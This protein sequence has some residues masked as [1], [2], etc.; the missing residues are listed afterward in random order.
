MFIIIVTV[1]T[2]K[3][4]SAESQKFLEIL[5]RSGLSNKD[6]A[7]KLGITPGQI[8]NITKGRRLPSRAIL[9]KLKDIYDVDLDWYLSDESAPPDAEQDEPAEYIVF[10]DQ[11]AAAGR[12]FEIEEHAERK[13]LPVPK[14]LL[15]RHNPKNV[16]AVAIGGDSMK[17]EKINEG[18]IVLFSK[19]V[20]SG[21]GIY[22]VS[23]GSEL[24]CKRVD[25]SALPDSLT[26]ISANPAYARREISNADLDT[27]KIEGRVIAVLHRE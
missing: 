17:D 4:E 7:R 10:Y 11:K 8:T 5:R 1:N 12:G 24:V 13:R 27:V 20:T 23:L 16:Y 6:F 21:N 14:S 19:D 22:I 9:A 15:G 25:F 3:E 2:V 18:D 26:L